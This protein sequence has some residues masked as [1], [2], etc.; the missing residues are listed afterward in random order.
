MAEIKNHLQGYKELLSPPKTGEIIKG[1]VIEKAKSCIILELGNYKIGLIKKEDL[2]AAGED[3]SKIKEGEE[4]SAKI[5]K[6]DNKDN[7]V[8]LSLREANKDLTWKKLQD[9]S[10]KREKIPLKVV[11]ANKGGLIF[12]LSGIQGFLPAS[13]LS[14]EHYPR[15]ENPIPD[16]ILQELKKFVGQELKVKIITVDSKRQKLIFSEK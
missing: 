15:I 11:G 5:I 13:Q 10:E 6:L 14:K 2:N 3:I 12:N 4:I 7:L 9:L 8:E 16:K 1:K